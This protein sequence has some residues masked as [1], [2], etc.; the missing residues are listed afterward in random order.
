ME[1]LR[2]EKLLQ[3]NKLK[4]RAYSTVMIFV[5]VMSSHESPS[6]HIG[7]VDDPVKVGWMDSVNLIVNFAK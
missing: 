4:T 3:K 5:D 7:Y 6:K 1:G 2:V